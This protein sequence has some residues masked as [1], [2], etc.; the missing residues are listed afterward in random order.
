M[1]RVPTL[2]HALLL[3]FDQLEARLDRLGKNASDGFPPYNIERTGDNALRVS[4]AVAGFTQEDLEILQEANELTI[5]GRQPPNEDERIFLHRG[6]AA[7]QFSRV[8]VLADGVQ[9]SG[10]R[11]EHGLLHIDLVQPP[12]QTRAQRIEIR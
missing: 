8:F 11:L 1:T 4:L 3:G 6:I 5:R 2:N 9:V 7:R 12:P 10:A